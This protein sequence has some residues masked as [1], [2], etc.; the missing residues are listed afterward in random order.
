V[1]IHELLLPVPPHLR[2]VVLAD[3]VVPLPPPL[4]TTPPVNDDQER[5]RIQQEQEAV[6]GVLTHLT[7]VAAE[8]HAQQRQRLEEM[9]QV[10]VDLAIAVASRL[11]HERIAAGDF[12]VE[13]LVREAVKRLPATQPVTVRLHP[14]DLQLL[15]KRMG[16]NALLVPDAAV[17]LVA[18]ASLER[19]DC[20]ADAG[21]VGVLSQM[22]EQLG[23]IR[24]HVLETLPAATLDRR[25]PDRGLRRFPDRRNT[26]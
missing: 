4:P 8:L 20:R 10:A 15:E 9:Q 6:Q 26:A 25:Q 12:A 17:R 5:L 7:E 13:S 14:L 18:D 1:V 19:G 16:P 21:E 3:P 11:L 24:R 2:E 23:E 22:R